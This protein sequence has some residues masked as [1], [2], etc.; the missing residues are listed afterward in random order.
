MTEPN[1][2]ASIEVAAPPQRVYALV[3]DPAALASCAEE[4]IG[5]QWLGGATKAAEGA[6]F[7]GRNRRGFRR[8]S[9]VSTITDTDEGRRFAFDVSSIGL[10]ISRWQYDIEP[11]GD[12][13]RLT[14]S[15]WD[16]RPGWL[17][18]ITG[19]VTGVHQRDPYNR[20]NIETTLRRIK[21]TAEGA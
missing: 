11:A 10:S 18:T 21:E 5:H 12:G 1:A 15:T 9:T 19:Y 8:W 17:R 13:V 16:R 2:S 6:R 7:R 4:Y 20:A 3:S 14:E